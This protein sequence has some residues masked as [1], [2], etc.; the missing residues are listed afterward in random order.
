MTQT[1]LVVEDEPALRQVLE[2]LLGREG[3]EVRSFETGEEALMAIAEKAP[4]VACL[5]VELPGMSGLQA[6]ERILKQSPQLPV[7][8]LTGESSVDTVVQAMRLGAFDYL[9]K[10]YN[11][12]RLL[13][14]LRNAI[15]IRAGLP[16][17][18]PP[19]P[20]TMIGESAALEAVYR[21]IDRVGGTDVTVLVRGETGTGKE[22]ASRAIHDA[23]ARANGPF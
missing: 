15:E 22:L 8:M 2:R 5:D 19:P 21:Q 20:R 16:S 23:S 17:I 3:Y 11:T 13:K 6:L 18:A 4:D 10:P 7:V 12:P 1:I 9:T 14:T